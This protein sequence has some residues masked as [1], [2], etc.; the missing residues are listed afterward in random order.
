MSSAR[1]AASW[2]KEELGLAGQKLSSSLKENPFCFGPDDAIL[3]TEIW[4]EDLAPEPAGSAGGEGFWALHCCVGR[5]WGWQTSG[6]RAGLSLAPLALEVTQQGRCR[7]STLQATGCARCGLPA[8][9]AP[10]PTVLT[11]A[12]TGRDGQEGH[13]EAQDSVAGQQPFVEDA[14]GWVGVEL[15]QEGVRRRGHCVE[16]HCGQEHGHVP[17]LVLG[18]A[19]EPGRGNRWA[20]TA[21]CCA[22]RPASPAL[23][24]GSAGLAPSRMP[25]PSRSSSRGRLTSFCSR[26]GQRL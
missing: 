19:R 17:A 1:I 25:P 21:A 4:A 8:P 9:P 10:T 14:A 22:P 23:A 20:E 12:D 5:D 18:G 7:S 2:F 11:E 15:V 3:G 13:E 6:K 16:A 24:S 26:C